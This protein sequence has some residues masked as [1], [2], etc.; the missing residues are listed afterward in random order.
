MVGSAIYRVLKVK[1]SL[2]I[3]GK[4]T[5]SELDLITQ[6]EVFKFLNKKNQK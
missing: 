3:I 2:N 6:N 5:N 4:S 1:G